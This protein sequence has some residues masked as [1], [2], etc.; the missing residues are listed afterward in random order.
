MC[1][2]QNKCAIFYKRPSANGRLVSIREG[3]KRNPLITKDNSMSENLFSTIGKEKSLERVTS[4][5]NYSIEIFVH[6]LNYSLW[7]G[8]NLFS[9][10]MNKCV[11]QINWDDCSKN[12]I[13]TQKT[14]FIVI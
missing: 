8:T 4:E 1:K 5:E 14:F 7:R 2:E 11:E 6:Q 12:T 10:F 13:A 3:I 9:H